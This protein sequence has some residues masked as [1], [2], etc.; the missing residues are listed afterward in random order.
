MGHRFVQT[1][2]RQQVRESVDSAK[3]SCSM[4][5]GSR[6]ARFAEDRFQVRATPTP[7]ILK[8][9]RLVYYRSLFPSLDRYDCK[10]VPSPLRLHHP[11]VVTSSSSLMLMTHCFVRWCNGAVEKCG[12][13]RREP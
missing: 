9:K 2:P 1:S 3:G 11:S 5:P 10:T 7:Q 12:A 13:G 6:R 4:C 8:E